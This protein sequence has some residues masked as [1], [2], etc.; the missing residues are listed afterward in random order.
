MMRVEQVTGRALAQLVGK[1]SATSQ[2]IPPAPLFYRH[3]RMALS[4]TLNQHPQ[5]YEALVPL[6]TEC[7]E[8][9]MW[10]DT[11]MINWNG[12]SLLKKEEGSGH[13]NRHRC[14]PDR[15]GSNHSEPEDQ[16]SM[17]PDRT[18]NAHKLSGAASCN[19]SSQ[20]IPKTSQNVS[21]P[22]VRQHHG[23]GIHKQPGRN[24]LQG[25]GRLSQEPMEGKGTSTSQPNTYQVFRM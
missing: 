24:S 22:Q 16:R 4:A 19:T 9:L 2:V 14:F 3:L 20:D 12:K 6:T 15:S 23:R 11:H 1:M 13:D 8:E 5:C 18:Q 10:W 21:T 25:I 7:R 17:V